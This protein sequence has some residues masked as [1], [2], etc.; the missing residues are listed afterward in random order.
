MLPVHRNDGAGGR[1]EVTEV[2]PANGR[3]RRFGRPSG[4]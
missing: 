4:S 3:H 1:D 2:L